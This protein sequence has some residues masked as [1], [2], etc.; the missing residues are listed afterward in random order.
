MG[1]MN[2]LTKLCSPQLLMMCLLSFSLLWSSLAFSQDYYISS[3]MGNDKN[4]GTTQTT[5]WKNL[6]KVSNTQFKP[7]DRILLKKADIWRERLIIPVSG[8]PSNKIIV[9]SYGN[10]E[11][12]IISG[13]VLVKN[14]QSMGNGIYFSPLNRK[15][16][17]LIEDGIPL[18]KSSSKSLQ[19]GNWYYDNANLYYKPTTGEPVSHIIERGSKSHNIY[20]SNKHDLIIDGITIYGSN[21]S[22]IK[23]EDSSRIEVKNCIARSNAVCGILIKSTKLNKPVEFININNNLVEWNAD[24]IYLRGKRV[25]HCEVTKNIIAYSNYE[26]VM[27]HSTTDGHSLGIMHTNNSSFEQNVIHHN[28][29]GIALWA[30]IA[31][32]SHN[33]IF[34]RNYIH[35]NQLFGAAQ[36]GDERNNSTNNIWAYNIIANNGL[37]DKRSGGFRINRQQDP[38]N[39]FINNT[40]VGNDV[41]IFLYSYPDGTIIE[42]NISL[43]PQE[44]HVFIYVTKGTRNVIDNNCYYSDS[45]EYFKYGR[46]D[47]LNYEEW[48]QIS[49]QDHNSFIKNPLLVN[50]LP[51]SDSDYFTNAK[52]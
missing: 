27:S 13:S 15:C 3:S 1:A 21:G 34:L 4:Q 14:W 38:P 45:E 22:G 40:L 50:N 33:N 39:F 52:T 41:N 9:S 12:P 23:I 36:G 18:R 35:D 49:G 51:A 16:H 6:K 25:N 43:N 7:G 44:Y 31:N 19:D 32:H 26:K 8:T 46:Q 10:G 24:G 2:L 48:K 17:T 47:N 20:I 42:N 30:G 28:Y 11:K 5:P 29:T 37:V